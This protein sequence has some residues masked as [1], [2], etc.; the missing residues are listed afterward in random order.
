MGRPMT[1]PAIALPFDGLPTWLQAFFVASLV[2]VLALIVW[3]SVLLIASLRARRAAPAPIVPD[4]YLWVFVVPALDEEVTIRDSVERLLRVECS[5]RLVLVVDDGSQDA[6]PEVLAAIEHPDLRVLRRNLPDARTGKAAALNAAYD[7]VNGMLGEPRYAGFSRERVIVVIVDADGRLDPT[8][9]RY[10]A[11]HFDDRRVGGVQLLVRIYNRTGILT[12]LQ[13]V[14]FGIFAALFQGGRTG[15]GTASMG[16]NG[17]FNRLAALDAVVVDEFGGPWR[18]RLTEDQDL[19]LRLL[20]AGWRGVQEFRAAID[21]QGVSSGRALLRQRT[22]WAQGNLQA[23]EHLR[24]SSSV[25]ASRLARA[26]LLAS[27]LLPVLIGILAIEFLVTVLIVSFGLDELRFA[28][29][30]DILAFY[31]LAFGPVLVG[32]IARGT[33]Y[34]ARGVACA[35]LVVH[36]FALYIYIVWPIYLRASIRQLSGRRAWAKTAR[37]PL[38]ADR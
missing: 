32:C 2:L 36:V 9:P 13:D 16:G 35:F 10:A 21:Q 26:D 33:L 29:L 38:E 7:H 31:V 1:L 8:S 37:E 23:M 17:Q 14:E 30:G 20:Q 5:H 25:R 12:W 28:D 18:N 3:T 6:T 15:S 34:G 27:V 24:A 19:G 22:R 11:A 4:E